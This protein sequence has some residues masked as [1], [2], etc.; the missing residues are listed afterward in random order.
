M[1]VPHVETLLQEVILFRQ[2]QP[3]SLDQPAE[4]ARVRRFAKGRCLMHQGA[5]A[6]CMYVILRGRVL[7]QRVH[8]DLREPVVLGEVV[9]GEVV[10][11]MGVLDGEPRSATVAALEQTEVLE[12][13]PTALETTLLRD[14]QVAGLLL[15]ILSNRLRSTDQLVT[16][17]VVASTSMPAHR[18]TEE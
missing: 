2:A 13:T 16:Q 3:T 6:S 15:R 5:A 8:P 14:P 11:E 18:G 17:R 9:T 12:I 4:Q 1:P 10:E 7:V